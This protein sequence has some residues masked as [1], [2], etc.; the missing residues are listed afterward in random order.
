MFSRTNEKEM[1]LQDEEINDT[2]HQENHLT[3][4]TVDLGFIVNEEYN[5]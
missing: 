1:S 3:N 2:W 4:F 5:A